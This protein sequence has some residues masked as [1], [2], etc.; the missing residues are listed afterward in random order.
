MPETATKNPFI[1][2]LPNRAFRGIEQ[3]RKRMNELAAEKNEIVK[4]ERNQS[5]V[6]I[7]TIGNN[8]FN[9]FQGECPAHIAAFLRAPSYMRG[10]ATKSVPLLERLIGETMRLGLERDE[11]VDAN[12]LTNKQPLGTAIDRPEHKNLNAC[13]LNEVKAICNDAWRNVAYIEIEDPSI[14]DINHLRI[15]FRFL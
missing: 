10:D 15:K 6:M 11:V 14:S 12:I 7:K 8:L 1:T 3:Q 2:G 9:L 5:L 13:H 4:K